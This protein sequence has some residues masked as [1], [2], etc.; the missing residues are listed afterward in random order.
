MT[1]QELVALLG[2]KSPDELSEEEIDLLRRRIA[3][4]AELREALYGQLQLEAYLAAALARVNFSPGD[5]LKRARQ[6]QQSQSRAAA[7]YLGIP[8]AVLA[9]VGMLFLFREA[10]SGRGRKDERA[11]AD[12]KRI[13]DSR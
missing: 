13:I 2:E 8:L 1:D 6:H 7:F 9:L 12:A 4:S 5:I 11:V 3:E 10:L